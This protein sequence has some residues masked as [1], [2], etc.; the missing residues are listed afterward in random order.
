MLT[1][2]GKPHRRGGFLRWDERGAISLTVGGTL[3]GGGLALPNLLAAEAK[4]GV[5]SIF[6]PCGNQHLFARRTP[7]YRH[8]GFEA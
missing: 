8:V 7:A 3:L 2:F 4:S 6:P 5:K 1:I